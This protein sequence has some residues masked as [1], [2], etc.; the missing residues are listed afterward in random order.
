M[1]SRLPDPRERRPGNLVFWLIA[2]AIAASQLLALYALCSRQVRQADERRDTVVL[3]VQQAAPSCRVP[4]G[5]D[6][7]VF[8]G[9]GGRQ[10]GVTDVR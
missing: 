9:P 3:A 4:T 7:A 8:Y 6:C 2:A 5:E 10:A 1:L